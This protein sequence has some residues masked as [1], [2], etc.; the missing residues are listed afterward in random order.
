VSFRPERPRKA[1]YCENEPKRRCISINGNLSADP[2]IVLLN[3]VQTR[4][5]R[6]DRPS[7]E[8]TNEIWVK[9]K[10]IPD[11]S[12]EGYMISLSLSDVSKYRKAPA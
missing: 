9:G 12:D 4:G 7:Y 11:E 6:L 5:A 1:F 3:F 10:D 8:V 2:L